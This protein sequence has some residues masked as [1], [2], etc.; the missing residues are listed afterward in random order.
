MEHIKSKIGKC[1]ATGKVIFPSRFEARCAMFRFKLRSRVKN[2]TDGRRI[3]HRMGKPSSRRA[4]YCRFCAGY[5][6]TKWKKGDFERYKKIALTW[7]IPSV[8]SNWN[9]FLE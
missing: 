1:R 2:V 9:Y 7:D 3:K 5:H 6:I 8:V 4:Y